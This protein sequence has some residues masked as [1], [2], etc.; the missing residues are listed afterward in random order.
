[1]NKQYREGHLVDALPKKKQ[2]TDSEGKTA[3]FARNPF[4]RCGGCVRPLETIRLLVYGNVGQIFQCI[5]LKSWFL[6]PASIK[7]VSKS[8]RI[9][10]PFLN[11]FS[12]NILY[13]FL[14][15]AIFDVSNQ[16]TLED[17]NSSF[18]CIVLQAG[19]F[20]ISHLPFSGVSW[21]Q[22]IDVEHHQA[23][24]S[25]HPVWLRPKGLWWWWWW[26]WWWWCN[27]HCTL[28]NSKNLLVNVSSSPLKNH[29]P[30]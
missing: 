10:M 21:K 24:S 6:N 16:K 27:K 17:S 3:G 19:N 2:R 7:D 8:K 4:S 11:L 23:T 25:G 29:I 28:V 1:M 14:D 18:W 15:L 22:S 13:S 26:W 12:W 30:T 9:C 20:W 5:S